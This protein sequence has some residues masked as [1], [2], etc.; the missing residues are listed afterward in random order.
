MKCGNP[1]WLG[2]SA[3]SYHSIEE[4]AVPRQ[5]HPEELVPPHGRLYLWL[6]NACWP[7]LIEPFNGHV[8]SRAKYDARER[9]AA[10]AAGVET[11]AQEPLPPLPAP[12]A[13]LRGGSKLR[14]L[15]SVEQG[16]S[17][18]C[19]DLRILNSSFDGHSLSAALCKAFGSSL[20]HC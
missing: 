5:C 3:Q 1:Q 10:M 19:R 6:N 16:S 4:E 8:C 7:Q 20:P 11:R 13:R 12:V 14:L 2:L 18:P 15:R 9:A 17:T